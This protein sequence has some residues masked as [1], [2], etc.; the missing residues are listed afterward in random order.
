[1]LKF[2]FLEKRGL[3]SAEGPAHRHSVQGLSKSHP[4]SSH[5]VPAGLNAAS[6]GHIVQK[7]RS[8]LVR[9]WRQYF[10]FDNQG[11]SLG[12]RI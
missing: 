1:M 9:G 2:A 11:Q 4:G 5:H 7:V 3:L 10:P 6:R 8:E 12:L